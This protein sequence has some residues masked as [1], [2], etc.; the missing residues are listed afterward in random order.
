MP[1][2]EVPPGPVEAGGGATPRLGRPDDSQ[3]GLGFL[4]GRGGAGEDGELPLEAADLADGLAVAAP[5]PL[6]L[7]PAQVGIEADE[8]LAEV[9]DLGELGGGGGTVG[10]AGGEERPG[11][12]ELVLGPVGVEVVVGLEG[13]RLED[14]EAA[15]GGG[16]EADG[17]EPVEPAVERQV[18]GLVPELLAGVGVG[19]VG[20]ALF[21][22]VEPDLHTGLI[23]VDES[24]AVAGAGSEQ[25]AED[26]LAPP[27]P[28]PTRQ[29]PDDRQLR[30]EG[31]DDR[32]PSG[33][34][35]ELLEQHDRRRCS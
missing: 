25:R 3:E 20:R 1:V 30:V 10:L 9:V 17:L 34:V 26:A 29:A 8:A 5:R 28:G 27:L 18:G 6:L 14:H 24:D 11:V 2:A 23:S 12:G 35:G 16:V 15:G 13:G 22:A 31:N 19:D 7:E 33:V 4:P 21:V 32:L